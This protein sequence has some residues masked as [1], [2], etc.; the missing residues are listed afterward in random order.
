MKVFQP[1][2]GGSSGGGSIP[3][4]ITGGTDG[5]VLFIHP[6]NTLA[7]DNNQFYLQDSP[8]T[9]QQLAT[10]TNVAFSVNA[11]G[12]FTGTDAMNIYGQYDA[13]LLN[14]QITNSL[15]GLNTDGAFPG[16]T[17]SS[18]RGTAVSIA[19][20]QAN[21][22]V[23]GYFGFGA[24]GASS[25]TYQNLGGMAILTT[26]ATTNNLGGEVRFYTKADGG[27]LAQVGSFGN[28]GVFN[29]GVQATVLALAQSTNTAGAQFA[30]IYNSTNY[31][32]LTTASTGLS[33][34]QVAGGTPGIVFNAGN[35]NV[36]F[37]TSNNGTTPNVANFL[38]PSTTAS[39]LAGTGPY[40]QFGVATSAQ[41]AGT[42]QMQYLGAGN[43]GNFMAFGMNGTPSILNVLST[44][45]GI[46]TTT[47][48]DKLANTPNNIVDS[49]GVGVTGSGSIV[50]AI[51]GAGYAHAMYNASS[52][53]NAQ[54]LLVK[55]AGTASTNKAFTVN[56][57]AAQGTN[58]TD[59]FS[60][61]GNGTVGIGLSNP[62]FKQSIQVAT[63][64]STIVQGLS[65]FNPGSGAGTGARIGLGYSDALV[66]QAGIQGYFDGTAAALGIFT[67]GVTGDKMTILSNGNV[68]IGVTTPG[69]VL[70]L[71]AGTAT[72]S[73]APLKFTSG[74]NLTTAE[75]GATEYDGT[76][77]FFTPTGTIRKTIPTIVMGR[78][79][80]QTAAVASIV[81]QTVGAAD[82]SYTISANV[83]VTTATVHSFTVICAYTDEGNTART[84]TLQLSTIAG[85]FVTAITN[86][87][88]TVP[89]EGV[90]LHIRAIAGSTI[91]LATTGTFTT[92]TYNVEGAITQL[93]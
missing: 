84:L 54:G 74:T 93:K 36:T 50:W 41:N 91:T 58:G 44:K 9:P 18:A 86:A 43:A 38:A 17:S 15:A 10:N 68:G 7:Q 31:L 20:L 72:A 71:K 40:F 79:T 32:T 47:P 24:Q 14:S 63:T 48:F 19:Q 1:T 16:Y 34:F 11:S 51:N 30:S 27:S 88:G 75:A 42:I 62:A 4:T 35:G 39:G 67:G 76:N 78:Q 66:S 80:A 25:P 60:V 92:V 37:N 89:Y 21:D 77:L 53:S 12:D 64:N 69:A 73:T 3:G 28:N 8:T 59:I 22:M 87:Q 83:L 85:A 81:T 13:F 5:S 23:G 2:S 65:I 6:V 61:L 70:H 57:A 52:A 33:T 49:G 82:T 26:G 56:T 90:P 29:V 45:V 46:G 55:I